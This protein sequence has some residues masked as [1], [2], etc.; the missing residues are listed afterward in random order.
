MSLQPLVS[1]EGSTPGR[2]VALASGAPH[3]L[4]L[5]LPLWRAADH[6]PIMRHIGSPLKS[7]HVA[8]RLSAVTTNLGIVAHSLLA[9]L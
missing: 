3:K 2:A 6:A 9:P 4:R 8:H 1:L 7:P 5:L